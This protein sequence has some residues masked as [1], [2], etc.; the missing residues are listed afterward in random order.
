MNDSTLAHC[1]TQRID[2]IDLVPGGAKQAVTNGVRNSDILDHPDFA[3][4]SKSLLF[5]RFCITCAH[6]HM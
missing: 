2:R 3:E 6:V 5:L 4:L 1:T